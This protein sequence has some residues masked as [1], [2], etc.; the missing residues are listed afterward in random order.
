LETQSARHILR[1]LPRENAFY[2]F[3]SIGNY[4][5]ESAS[6]LEEFVE[7]IKH[8]PSISLEFHQQRGDFEKWFAQT[9]GDT[10]LA[11]E[12]NKLRDLT[13]ETLREKLDLTI[14]KRYKEL[15]YL[16]QKGTR[17]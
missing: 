6:S 13:G 5:G 15:K 12:I 10:E 7:K 9:L 16:A 1:K 8:L 14:S 17:E 2:F 3:T 4:V 11:E